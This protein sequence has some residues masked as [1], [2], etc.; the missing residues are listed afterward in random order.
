LWERRIAI[1]ATL[2]LIKH[3]EIDDTF[4]L[5]TALLKDR[6]DLMHKAVGWAL[7]ETGKVSRP[8]LL[9][10]LEK[11]YSEMPRTALRYAIEH[12]PPGQRKEIL[13]GQFQPI[14]RR[15]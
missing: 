2:G 13:A 14:L 8:A 1:V 3:G 5:A 4:R 6:H 9:H 10:F 12:L 15:R 7:R 11:H